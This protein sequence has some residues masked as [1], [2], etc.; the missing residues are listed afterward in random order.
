MAAER[1]THAEP[2]QAEPQLVT[3]ESLIAANTSEASQERIH[4]YK[5]AKEEGK[6]V[7][8]KMCADARS[9]PSLFN[10]DEIAIERSI[11]AGI[12]PLEFAV[13]H[14]GV[15]AIIIAPHFDGVAS[16]EAGYFNG[17]GGQDA[18]GAFGGIHKAETHEHPVAQYIGSNVHSDNPF[19]QAFQQKDDIMAQ[20]HH[21]GDFKPIL[22]GAVDHRTGEFKPV[23]CI[24]QQPDG[25]YVT[26]G[27]IQSHMLQNPGLITPDTLETIGLERINEPFHS[28][29]KKNSEFVAANPQFPQ[30]QEVQNP[31]TIVVTTSLIPLRNR[32]AG[33][34]DIPNTVF[35]VVAPFTKEN[36]GDVHIVQPDKVLAQVSYPIDKALHAHGDNDPFRDTKTIIFEASNMAEARVLA[37]GFTKKAWAQNWLG[38]GGRMIVAETKS[39]QTTRAEYLEL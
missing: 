20:F 15:R 14:K 21:K 2:Q 34:F 36:N 28:M 22:I 18:Y 9:G 29:V 19:V 3:P 10:S 11:A 5:V 8:L 16:A 38:E 27:Y 13:R 39:G 24:E 7:L 37:D 26:R 4:N 25:M 33:L 12:N 23:W 32:Y 17:C 31:T 1:P 30:T 6:L 35:V